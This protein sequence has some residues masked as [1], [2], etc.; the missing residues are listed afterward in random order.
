MTA[1]RYSQLKLPM[2]LCHNGS[3]PKREDEGYDPAYKY[4]L[5]YKTIVHNCDGLTLYADQ[6]QVIDESTWGHGGYGEACSGLTGRLINKR[7]AKGG[8]VVI[9]SD[10]GRCR[11]RA[12]LHRHKLHDYPKEFAR[13][14]TCELHYLASSLLEMV[15]DP[16]IPTT[17]EGKKKIF[18]R[19]MGFTVDTF[20]IVIKVWIGRVQPALV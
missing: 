5:I 20:S 1:T 10:H 18:Q 11:P 16:T 13:I 6:N 8:Q 9:T 4:D 19:K 14:G 7:V 17:S 12:Y 2:K 3:A 15:V